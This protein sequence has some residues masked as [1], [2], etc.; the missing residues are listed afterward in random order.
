MIAAREPTQCSGPP[1][2]A[3]TRP[4]V[5]DN[6]GPLCPEASRN[7]PKSAENQLRHA[8]HQHVILQ[9]KRADSGAPTRRLVSDR[10]WVR[11]PSPAFGVASTPRI[12]AAG[13]VL[14]TRAPWGARVAVGRPIVPQPPLPQGRRTSLGRGENADRSTT[15]PR[16]CVARRRWLSAPVR[17]RVAEPFAR[18]HAHGHLGSPRGMLLSRPAPLTRSG[19]ADDGRRGIGGQM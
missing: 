14:R 8:Y 19:R 13:C 18:R 12:L 16:R 15:L 11:V 5:K 10:S 7:Q 6:G 3:R 9:A 2:P 1:D 17:D 4:I